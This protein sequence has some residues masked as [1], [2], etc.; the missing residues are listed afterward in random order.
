MITDV[1]DGATDYVYDVFL[2]YKR[3]DQTMDWTR[4]VQEKLD[5]WLSQEIQ[6]PVKMFRDV[7]SIDVGDRWPNKLKE[8][9]KLSKCMVGVWSPLY[10]QSSWC[11][12][13]W[14][15]FLQREKIVGLDSHGLIAPVRFHDG[16]HFP[17][18]ARAVQSLDFRP[19]AS[20]LPAFWNSPRSLEL[21][22][23]IKI[24]ASAVARI[25]KTV[26]PFRTDWPIVEEAGAVAPRIP[27]ARL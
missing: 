21:E 22:D 11:V 5:F 6:R 8:G 9:L 17:P 16:E 14:R 4:K 26:P 10:F 7:D 12:S 27:L 19:Y 20:S 24:L 23:Q 1:M 2:S 3:H 18:E 25:L 13:E 15:S